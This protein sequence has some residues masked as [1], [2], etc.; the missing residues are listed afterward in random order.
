MHRIYGDGHQTGSTGAATNPGVFASAVA[1]FHPDPSA[2]YPAVA[3]GIA[4]L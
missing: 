1:F 3:T 4:I 2:V